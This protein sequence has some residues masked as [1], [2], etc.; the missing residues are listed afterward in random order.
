MSTRI[1]NSHNA[2]AMC[3]ALPVRPVR[4]S[5]LAYS[6]FLWLLA[7]AS[8]TAS[9]AI[10]SVPEFETLVAQQAAVVV[11]ID[12]VAD[13]NMPVAGLPNPG[14]QLPEFFQHYFNFPPPGPGSTPAPEQHAAGS[15]FIISEDGYILSN[16]H[17]VRSA[18]DITVRLNDRREFQARLVGADPRTDIALLKI[19]AENLPVAKFG[20]SD[21]LRVGQW[22]LA[23]GAPFGL[24]HT[25]TQGIV[26]ALGRDLPNEQYI[27][28]IQTDVALNP[29]NSGGPL[30]NLN[31]EV[32]GI[33]SQIFSRTGGYM[34]LSFA[35][36]I[37]L[38]RNIA[39]QL[40]DNGSIDR[41]WLGVIIQDLN[42]ELAESFGLDKPRGA[43][44]ARV[45]PNSPADRAS[46]QSGDVI[47][48][49][50]GNP[51]DKASKLP[52]LVA[53][54]R[55]GTDVTIGILRNGHETSLNLTVAKLE[56]PAQETV[57]QAQPGRLGFV[58]SDLTTAERNDIGITKGGARI[59]LVAP[60]SPAAR[61]GLRP[62]DVIISFN[63]ENIDNSAELAELARK[64][65]SGDSV[66]I[67][68]QRNHGAQFLALRIPE[69][70]G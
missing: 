14:Q 12:V 67:L 38:A 36:P 31:G 9:A 25:A 68:V 7:A 54:T 42:Q 21:A 35:I 50:D 16:A 8:T 18:R 2:A 44:V 37:N 32:V 43:L 11:N 24:D 19:D 4:T 26:S 15:G 41:G 39:D 63:H 29:G 33:N 47:L 65:K 30:F 62:T 1:D 13:A 10:K 49:F 61:S 6:L 51:I 69:Q 5:L 34:G 58:A 70:T 48:S 53:A 28:F 46:M 22:V 23:I 3:A 55:I 20:N 57:A 60:G 56:D 59:D 45:T 52:S 17:V 40:K 27:P 64:A 66:P